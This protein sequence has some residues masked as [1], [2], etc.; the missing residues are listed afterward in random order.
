MSLGNTS[1][2]IVESRKIVEASNDNLVLNL[3]L[4]IVTKIDNRIIQ[5]EKNMGKRL[6]DMNADFLAVSTRVR[7][8]ENKKTNFRN[9]TDRMRE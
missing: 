1:K 4:E 9:K 6:D 7:S 5:M 8:L 2:L 3:I